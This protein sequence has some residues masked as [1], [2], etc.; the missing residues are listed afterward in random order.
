MK[1]AFLYDCVFCVLFKKSL[2]S[3][4]KAELNGNLPAADGGVGQMIQRF[5]YVG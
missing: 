2:K 3:N 5:S 1:F 4:S